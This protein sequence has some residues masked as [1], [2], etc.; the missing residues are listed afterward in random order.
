MLLEQRK[1][2]DDFFETENR[3]RESEAAGVG[4]FCPA[5][6]RPEDDYNRLISFVCTYKK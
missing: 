2:V 3:I 1:I 5:D 6:L 4:R